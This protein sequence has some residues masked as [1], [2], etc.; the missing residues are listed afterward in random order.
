MFILHTCQGHLQGLVNFL[1]TTIS[2]RPWHV[3]FLQPEEIT[4]KNIQVLALL[5]EASMQRNCR[6]V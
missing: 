3:G 2:P 1:G 6:M 5:K 4:P